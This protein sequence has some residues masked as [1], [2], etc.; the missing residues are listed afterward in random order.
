MNS[1][2]DS[3]FFAQYSD[4]LTD[5]QILWSFYIDFSENRGDFL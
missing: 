3:G 4:D 1:S 2:V 5:S